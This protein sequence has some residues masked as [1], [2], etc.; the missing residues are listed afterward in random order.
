MKRDIIQAI[1]FDFGGV[2]AE[3]GFEEGL[4]AIG[5]QKGVDPESFFH[6]ASEII[7]ESHYV[8]GLSDEKTYWSS[9]RRQTGVTGTDREFREEIIKRFALRPTM[10]AHAIAFSRRGLTIGILSD[11]TD[12]LDEIDKRTPFYGHFDYVFN[13]YKMNKSKRDPSVFRDVCSIM[14]R[15]PS[16]VLFVDDNKGNIERATREGLKTIH[17][18][19]IK[20]FEEQM[21]AYA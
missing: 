19:S 14:G 12:W 10:I 18:R 7:H 3:E 15:I 20:G 4:K 13:S 2:L 11:Q 17:F 9:V 21:R 16:E 1:L 8:T 5:K 6:T